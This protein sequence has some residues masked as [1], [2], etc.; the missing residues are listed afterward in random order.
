MDVFTKVCMTLVVISA[1]VYWTLILSAKGALTNVNGKGKYSLSRMEAETD[2]RQS[3]TIA[4]CFALFGS[5]VTVVEVLHI[6]WNR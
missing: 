4:V 2:A 3:V 6:V 1:V 5:F